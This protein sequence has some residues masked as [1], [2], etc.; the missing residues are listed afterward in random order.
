MVALIVQY[1]GN[2]SGS[3]LSGLLLAN[4]L[5]EAGWETHVVFGFQG[6]LIEEYEKSGHA[7]CVIP[8]ESWLRRSRTH[9]FVKD[10]W[11]EWN[12]SSVFESLFDA[13]S[14]DVI[15]LNTAVSLSGAVAARRSMIPCVWHLREMWSDVGGEMRAPAWAVPLVR[16]TI[17]A[18]ADRVVANSEATAQNL[19]GERSEEATVIPNA[20]GASF[21]DEDRSQREAQSLFGLAPD[22]PVIGVPATLRPMKGHPFFFDAVAPVLRQRPE[23]QVAVTGEGPDT[24]TDQLEEQLRD[25]GIRDRVEL[26]GWV[27]DMS[28]FYRAC[29]LVCLPSR[30]EPFGRTAIE[31]F[32]IGTPVVATAV[33]GLQH[34]VADRQTGLLV[35]YGDEEAF[36]AAIRQLLDSSDLRQMIVA[37]ARRV[38]RSKYHERVYKNRIRSLVAETIP[39]NVTLRV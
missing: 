35:S 8:H 19:L 38:V 30:A 21:F 17:H 1:S 9:R 28:A 22:G 10:V 34:I 5:R 16:W 31:A 20:V 12:R 18:H 15:Y 24:F 7:T 32:A 11:R 2:R 3:G 33:G 23:V 27:E 39:S 6:P 13:M 25:L 26:L 37:N 14:P 36:A 4:G 29:D